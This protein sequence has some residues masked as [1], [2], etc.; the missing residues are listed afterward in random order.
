MHTYEELDRLFYRYAGVMRRHELSRAGIHACTLKRFIRSGYMIKARPGYYEW[1]G[2]R[3]R[4]DVIGLIIHIFPEA[5]ICAESALFLRGYVDRQPMHWHLAVPKNA[6]RSKFAQSYPPVKAHYRTPR[7]LEL[8]ACCDVYQG[9]LVP[10]YDRERT[11]CDCV[12][13]RRLLDAAVYRAALQ[14]YRSDPHRDEARLFA[15][16]RE[17]RMVQPLRE[18]LAALG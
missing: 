17:L 7:S 16:A 14:A 5:Y 9:Q 1:L 15:Y 4:S 18:A 6:T 11:I 10:M 3:K 2:K 13:R 8:G 12:A